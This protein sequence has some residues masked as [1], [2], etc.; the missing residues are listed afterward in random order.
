MVQLVRRSLGMLVLVAA[1]GGGDGGDGS[2]DDATPVDATPAPV[3]AVALAALGETCAVDGGCASGHCVGDICCDTT[4]E[5]ACAACGSDGVCGA[6]PEATTCRPAVDV[7]DQAEACDGIS[8]DCPTDDLRAADVVCREAAGGCDLNEFCTGTD[9]ACPT[10]QVEM[11]GVACR[12]AAE[13]GCDETEICNGVTPACPDDAPAPAGRECGLYVCPG[14]DFDCPT[15]CDAQADCAAGAICSGGTCQVGQW[16]FVTSTTHNGNFGGLTGADAFCQGRADAA[17]LPGTYLAWL[18]DTTGSPSTRF[19]VAGVPYFQPNGGNAVKVVDSTA[20]LLD[21]SLDAPL[22]RTEAGAAVSALPWTN[23]NGAG[24]ALNPIV[25]C[26]A[27]TSGTNANT[28][29]LGSTTATNTNWTV[30]GGGASCNS[31]YPLFC[32]AQ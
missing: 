31:S 23:V 3:D 24:A 28:G 27:W 29:Q 6:V 20:D 7:C 30:G 17:G 9:V 14:E 21:G 32:F 13:G 26:V 2:V 8:Q 5:G 25:S 18:G 16:A 15:A 22:G 1:C 11:S 10:D 4:C 19:T 12:Q